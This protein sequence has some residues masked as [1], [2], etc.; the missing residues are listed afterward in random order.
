MNIR[1]SELYIDDN[2]INVKGTIVIAEALR[3]NL[4]LTTIS[5]VKNNIADEGTEAI[6]TALTINAQLT[7]IDIGSNN[8]TVK[9]AI[10]IAE[11]LKIN[12]H[13]TEL[14]ISANVIGDE[15]AYIIAQALKK[16]EH[17]IILDIGNNNIGNRGSKEIFEALKT[18]PSSRDREISKTKLEKLLLSNNNITAGRIETIVNALKKNRTLTM[19]DLS[20]NIKKE[21][22]RR[23]NYKKIE[24]KIIDL[25]QYRK[26][27]NLL[28]KIKILWK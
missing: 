11:A 16:N 17:L 4:G 9:G 7:T 28:T 6:A 10:A 19:V 12:V 27:K 1:L 20:L 13:L 24:Q 15:G 23:D 22:K 18:E 8:I 3:T 14:N 2:L 26:Q 21:E 5:I 25:K